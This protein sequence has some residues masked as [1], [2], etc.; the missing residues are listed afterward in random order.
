MENNS[1]SIKDKILNNLIPIFFGS[2]GVV[3][4]IIAAITM[5]RK[6]PQSPADKYS[7]VTNQNF[8]DCET[9]IQSYVVD[10]G[11]DLYPVGTKIE[12]ELNFYACNKGQRNDVVMIKT[13]GREQPLI[14]YIKMIPGDK[15]KVVQG[16]D[17]KFRIVINGNNMENARGEEY[18][19]AER[20]VKMIQL[21]ESNFKNGIKDDVYFV[22]GNEI[23]GGFDSTRFGPVMPERMIGKVLTPPVDVRRVESPAE[24]LMRTKGGIVE[25]SVAP[26]KIK[27]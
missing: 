23:A 19:F 21:Y 18:T 2:A 27:K 11:T 9:K 17:G 26:K 25:A 8:K 24:I 13:P 5:M 6:L 16:K 22:F 20:K 14:K 3:L 15:Y 7:T 10:G 1:V 12:V 4:L